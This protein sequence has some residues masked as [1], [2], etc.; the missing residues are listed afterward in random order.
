MTSP[1]GGPVGTR[2][3]GP[4]EGTA[5]RRTSLTG[6]DR[7]ASAAPGPQGR[8]RRRSRHQPIWQERNSPLFTAVKIG[9]V[10]VICFFALYPMLAVL[11][12]SLSTRGEIAAHG[13]LVLFPTKPSLEAYR[14]IFSG[15]VVTQA[16]IRS[17][18][19]TAVGTVLSLLMTIMM[20]YALSRRDLWGGKFFLMAALLTMLF[21]A[22]II[23][24]FLVVRQLGLLGT[25][26]AVILPGAMSAF[27]LIVVRSFFMNI[28]QELTEAARIDGAGDVMVLRRIVLPLSKGV[29]AVVGLFYGV[30]YWN[31]FFTAMLYLDSDKWPLSMI[32]RQYVLLGSPLQDSAAGAEITA[33]SQAIQMAVVVVSLIPIL[34][35]FPFVQRFFTAGVITGAVKG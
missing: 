15:G 1:A 14:L 20:A 21:S 3:D 4:D 17:I 10:V 12:T 9:A 24:N 5:S 26:A 6:G 34:V 30:G 27:N 7:S 28:P 22:G 35:A 8:K 31:N 29:I 18:A 33:P 13:G 19:I 11:A 23:P 2:G 25:Y 16:L 32:L